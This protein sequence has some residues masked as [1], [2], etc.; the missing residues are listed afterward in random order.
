M[1]MAEVFTLTSSQER[2]GT[3]APQ[4]KLEEGAE[5]YVSVYPMF[6]AHVLK[7]GVLQPIVP[8]LR[9]EAPVGGCGA[10]RISVRDPGGRSVLGKEKR[11]AETGRQSV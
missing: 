6:V 5:L 2:G 3:G 7:E 1:A 9:C 8:A 10:V 11:S 4:H